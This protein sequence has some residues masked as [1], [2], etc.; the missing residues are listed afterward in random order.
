MNKLAVILAGIVIAGVA[1]G[2]R[3]HDMIPFASFTI[4]SNSTVAVTNDYLARGIA[5]SV[6]VYVS[7]SGPVTAQVTSVRSDGTRNVTAGGAAGAVAVGTPYVT[8]LTFYP[9]FDEKL[10]LTAISGAT[11]TSTATVV[12]YLLYEK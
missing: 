9:L 7:G 2:Q 3:L 6:V 8:N 5:K 10:V 4:T 12:G 11:M 1:Y